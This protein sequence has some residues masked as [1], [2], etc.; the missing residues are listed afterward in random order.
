LKREYYNITT[1]HGRGLIPDQFKYR[2]PSCEKEDAIDSDE[3]PE[4]ESD[5]ES[6]DQNIYISRD[7]DS[8][9]LSL[10]LNDSIPTNDVAFP[11]TLWSK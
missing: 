5:P 9:A 10:T 8:Y 2:D 3:D 11:I 1:D 6:T 7:Y 4:P